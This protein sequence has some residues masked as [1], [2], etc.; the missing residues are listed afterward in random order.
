MWCEF[1]PINLYTNVKQ[2]TVR[3]WHFR[4]HIY[5]EFENMMLIY[6]I[7]ALLSATSIH[8]NA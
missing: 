7:L 6:Y 2:R 3:D 8:G 1:P 4:H 5:V